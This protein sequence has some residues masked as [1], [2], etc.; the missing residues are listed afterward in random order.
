MARIRTITLGPWE[1]W[2][3]EQPWGGYVSVPDCG[4]MVD[5]LPRGS[6]GSQNP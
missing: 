4:G 6:L 1:F 5:M 3:E 2:L